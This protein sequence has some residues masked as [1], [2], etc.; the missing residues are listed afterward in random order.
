MKT[1]SYR[2]GSTVNWGNVA[3][4]TGCTSILSTTAV[5]AD[6]RIGACCGLGMRTVPELQVGRVGFTTIAEAD[7][8]CRGRLP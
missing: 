5:Q 7:R 1:N 4:R 6:G 8:G 2:D 3:T